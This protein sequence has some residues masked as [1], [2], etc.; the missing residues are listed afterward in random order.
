MPASNP[1]PFLSR[2]PSPSELGRRIKLLRISRG[3]TLKDLEERGGISAT[4]VSEI[5]RGKASPTVGALGRIALA[6]GLRPATLVEPHVLPEVTVGR[7]DERRN[8]R[9][10]WGS[11]MLEALVP[12]VEGALLGAQLMTLPIGREPALAHRH[13]GEE[14]VTVVTGV[15]EIRVEERPYVLR[16][17]D[18]LHFRAH[19][20][21]SYA[22][23]ASAPAVLLVAVR[24]RLAL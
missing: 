6:L 15:A 16:Q 8:Q 19:R 5:E 13:E 3:L 20:P 23:L 21:H 22:N 11:A 9:V 4:H 10:Q 24:P 18:S 2:D 7:A 14:W 1:A 12:P 17:G